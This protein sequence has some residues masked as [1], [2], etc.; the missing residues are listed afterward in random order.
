MKRQTVSDLHESEEARCAVVRELRRR[1]DALRHVHERL[2]RELA[3]LASGDGAPLAVEA[4]RE[5]L[6]RTTAQLRATSREL[7]ASI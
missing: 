4:M 2:T 3:A 5:E 1:V 6:A 7:V